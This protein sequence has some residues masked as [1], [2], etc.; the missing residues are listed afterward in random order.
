MALVLRVVPLRN[1][2][3]VALVL[4]VVPLTLL[5]YSPATCSRGQNSQ[6]ENTDFVVSVSRVVCKLIGMMGFSF[7]R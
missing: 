4:R 3:V 6:D 7:E 1:H 2:D 5:F